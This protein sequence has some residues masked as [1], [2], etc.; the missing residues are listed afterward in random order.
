M[1]YS[2]AEA[3][4]IGFLTTDFL[5]LAGVERVNCLSYTINS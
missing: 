3:K 2:G 1:R 5:K 4:S